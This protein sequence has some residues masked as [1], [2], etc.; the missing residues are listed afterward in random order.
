MHWCKRFV[1]PEIV[2]WYFLLGHASPDLVSRAAAEMREHADVM[3][4]AQQDE[5]KY[6]HIGDAYELTEQN[7]EMLKIVLALRLLKGLLS[8]DYLMVADDDSFISLPNL[9]EILNLVPK[10]RIYMGNMIDT[11]PQRW[12]FEKQRMQAEYTVNLYLAAP[13]KL[14]IFA[15]G[16]GFV[17]SSD[18]AD[19]F[20][21]MGLKLKLRSND[22][23]LLGVWL[24]SVEHLY[25]LHYFP[26]FY[27]HS[28][29]GSVF[30][31]PCDEAAI[32]TH[33]MDSERWR[34]FSTDCH[35]CGKLQYPWLDPDP[36]IEDPPP[37]KLSDGPTE[38]VPLVDEHCIRAD[39][40][41]CKWHPTAR[42]LAVQL[43]QDG[44]ELRCTEEASNVFVPTSR[45]QSTLP[46]ARPTEF[47]VPNTPAK[48][49]EIFKASAGNL[50]LWFC[51]V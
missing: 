12:N 31:L 32:L 34:T 47:H 49:E 45:L 16:M 39:E 24:R 43:G 42:E 27:D 23:L 41:V 30:S 10:E 2:R 4:L 22:D 3:L 17:V 44:C 5:I 29:Y 15:H 28:S 6:N 37:Q 38:M 48:K 26:W 46:A 25:Y 9:A 36:Q 11:I 7:A 18:V 19:F 50:H 33:R 8:F 14:P 13:S 51:V 40:V 21:K 35:V 1:S 20:R